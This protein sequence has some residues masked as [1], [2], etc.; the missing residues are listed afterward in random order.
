[1]YKHLSF[2]IVYTYIYICIPMCVHD[3]RRVWDHRC[4]T[5][6]L[7][8]Q[9]YHVCFDCMFHVPPLHIATKT[10]SVTSM[11]LYRSLLDQKLHG[12]THPVDCQL[13]LHP[14]SYCIG[15]VWLYAQDA[16]RVHHIMDGSLHRHIIHSTSIQLVCD[17][18][19]Y[20]L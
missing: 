8:V 17:M 1:M 11:Q 6:P 14:I 2:Y 5:L 19:A 7:Y 4:Q 15:Q 16:P 13:R 20:I 3:T 9:V 10:M 18:H 12:R